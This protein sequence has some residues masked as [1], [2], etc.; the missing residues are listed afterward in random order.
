MLSSNYR[1][2]AAA[3]AR[4]LGKEDTEEEE[5]ELS[6]LVLLASPSPKATT[7]VI[8]ICRIPTGRI[9]SGLRRCGLGGKV[10]LKASRASFLLHGR[11]LLAAV[12]SSH[13]STDD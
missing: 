6:E 9:N 1:K 5:E 11:Y 10:G 4:V 12:C 7:G 2:P 8:R 13:C 3:A